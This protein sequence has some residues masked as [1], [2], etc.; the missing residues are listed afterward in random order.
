ML[1]KNEIPVI[2]TQSVANLVGRFALMCDEGRLIRLGQTQKQLSFVFLPCDAYMSVANA[3]NIFVSYFKKRIYL[4]EN[5]LDGGIKTRI[6]SNKELAC[7]FDIVYNRARFGFNNKFCKSLSQIQTVEQ[8]T[9]FLACYENYEDKKL[10]AILQF[11]HWLQNVAFDADYMVIPCARDSGYIYC[12]WR[13]YEAWQNTYGCKNY[14][15]TNMFWKKIRLLADIAPNL[16]FVIEKR[17]VKLADGT[18]CGRVFAVRRLINNTLNDKKSICGRKIQNS[19]NQS[20]FDTGI[21]MLSVAGR[22]QPNNKKE[23]TCPTNYWN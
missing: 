15:S 16:L 8:M 23:K 9:E 6:L 22:E 3:R 5:T 11:M 14:I 7:L 4:S 13:N 2:Y 17:A 18:T 21:K 12:A 1:C 10:Y 19:N 20:K